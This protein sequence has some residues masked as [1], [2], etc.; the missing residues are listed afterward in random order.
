MTTTTKA[1][2]NAK[3]VARTRRSYGDDLYGWVENARDE[4][5]RETDLPDAASRR[6][7][8]MIGK[9]SSIVQSNS[10]MCDRPVTEA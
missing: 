4:A 9:P 10:A 1:R 3:V 7:A 5:M 6:R 8:L 2:G